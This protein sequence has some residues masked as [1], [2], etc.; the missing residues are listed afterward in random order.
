MNII[1]YILAL[2]F[3]ASGAAKLAGLE[4]EVVAFERWGYGIEFMYFTGAVEELG[5]IALFIPTLVRY[6]VVGLSGVMIGAM[7]THIIHQEWPML[8][9]ATVIFILTVLQVKHY[10]LDKKSEDASVEPEASA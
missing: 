10:W 1:R 9:I 5:A 2:I 4:F 3:F 8:A 6:S 7:G